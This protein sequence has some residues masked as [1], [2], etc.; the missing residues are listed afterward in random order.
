[1]AGAAI[2]ASRPRIKDIP[3]ATTAATNRTAAGATRFDSGTG[4]ERLSIRPET[5]GGPAATGSVVP[6]LE[7]ADCRAAGMST[8]S[9][10]T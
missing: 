3:N 5:A 4:P 1:M 8:G 2:A 6:L 10:G 9:P 7:S